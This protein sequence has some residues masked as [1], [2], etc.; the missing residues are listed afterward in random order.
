MLPLDAVDTA[1]FFDKLV[2][3]RSLRFIPHHFIDL[4]RANK[5]HFAEKSFYLLVFFI[6]N[7]LHS[8]IMSHANAIQMFERILYRSG[9]IQL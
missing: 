5:V 6:V 1:F 4:L 8:A 7:L 2:D 3:H 9:D